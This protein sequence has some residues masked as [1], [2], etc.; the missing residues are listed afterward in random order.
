[1]AA[2]TNAWTPYLAHWNQPNYKRKIF[3]N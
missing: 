1:M 3:Q 2:D